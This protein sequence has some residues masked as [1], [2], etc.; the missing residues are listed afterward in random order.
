MK[1]FPN[2]FIEVTV[3]W[4]IPVNSG[5]IKTFFLKSDT[6]LAHR[7]SLT[8]HFSLKTGRMRP[9]ALNADRFSPQ[10]HHQQLSYITHATSP[11]SQGESSNLFIG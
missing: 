1:L 5:D 6:L 7:H 3:I 9:I 8:C 10:R 4:I 11:D 2:T